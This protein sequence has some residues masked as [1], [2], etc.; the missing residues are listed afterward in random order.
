MEDVNIKSI[1]TDVT[2]ENHAI[3]PE[4]DVPIGQLFSTPMTQS[5]PSVGAIIA[6]LRR[7]SPSPSHLRPLPDRTNTASQVLHAM[8]SI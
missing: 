2:A 1:G 7:V 5:M 6:G 4:D 3:A 8:A